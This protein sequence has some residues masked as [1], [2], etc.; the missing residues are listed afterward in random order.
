LINE[1]HFVKKKRREIEMTK[2]L[3]T[4]GA[5][6]IGSSLTEALLQRDHFVRVLDD[7]STGKRENLIFDIWTDTVDGHLDAVYAYIA[8]DSPGHARRE[9]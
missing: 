4:G 6:F 5:G 7:F 3:I 1:D 8:Q 9:E 2:V